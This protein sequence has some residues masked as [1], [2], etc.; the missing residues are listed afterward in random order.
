MK[1]KKKAEGARRAIRYQ[2][3]IGEKSNIRLAK[4]ESWA[5]KRTNYQKRSKEN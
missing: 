2:R 5:L 4:Q 1:I 3:Y